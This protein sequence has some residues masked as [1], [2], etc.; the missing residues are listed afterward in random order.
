MDTE[1]VQFGSISSDAV[2]DFLQGW[3]DFEDA[4][5][6]ESESAGEVWSELP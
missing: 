1:L 6:S 3:A 4:I 5:V 2:S